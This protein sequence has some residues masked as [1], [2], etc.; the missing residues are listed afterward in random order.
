[1]DVHAEVAAVAV[2]VCYEA[3]DA[4]DYTGHHVDGYAEEVRGCRGVSWTMWSE[5][6]RARVENPGLTE[7]EIGRAHV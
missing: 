6:L 7:L 2:A 1:M 5:Q 4:G 3:D